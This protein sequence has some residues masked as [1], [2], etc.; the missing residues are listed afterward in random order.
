MVGQ[1]VNKLILEKVES[2]TFEDDIKKFV[3]DILDYERNNSHMAVSR[4]KSRYVELAENQF[5]EDES[6]E[7]H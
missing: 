7:I 3:K 2:S 1:R 5:K 6:D 4:Y